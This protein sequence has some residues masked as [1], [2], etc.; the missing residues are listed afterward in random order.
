MSD[1]GGLASRFLAGI[2]EPNHRE[3]TKHHP[4]R[5]AVLVPV[6]ENPGPSSRT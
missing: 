2:V 4:S 1:A 6:L 5:S 3:I